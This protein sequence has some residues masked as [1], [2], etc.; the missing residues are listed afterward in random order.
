[1]KYS[2]LNF[3]FCCYALGKPASFSSS[4]NNESKRASFGNDGKYYPTKDQP[5]F[6][7]HSVRQHRPW[8]RVD[9]QDD[10][11]ILAVNILNWDVSDQICHF[12]TLLSLQ[13]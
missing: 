5:S 11:C 1:M 8:W 9:L 13:L 12:H 3:T 10:F 7:A 4:Y 6:L 2:I